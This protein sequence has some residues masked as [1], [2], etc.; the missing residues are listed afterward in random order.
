MNFILSLGKVLYRI[1]HPLWMSPGYRRT[2][3]RVE[4]AIL[5]WWQRDPTVWGEG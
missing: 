4:D 3:G 5:Y 2:L 1:L